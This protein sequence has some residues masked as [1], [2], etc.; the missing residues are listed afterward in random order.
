MEKQ[1]I[2]IEEYIEQ[3]IEFHKEQ[4][5]RHLG[6]IQGFVKMKEDIVRSNEQKDKAGN[7]P[8]A[9]RKQAK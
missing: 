7:A 2:S 6:A 5:N 9:K 1:N 4:A 8:T 3:Q